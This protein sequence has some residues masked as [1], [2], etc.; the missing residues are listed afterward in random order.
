[1]TQQRESHDSHVRWL[2]DIDYRKEF[3]SEGAKLEIAAELVKAR[4][5]MKM[6]QSA[7]AK[8]ADTSQAYIAR[9]ERGDA[10]PTIGNIGRLFACMWLKPRIEPIPMEPL[11]SIESV[12]M[13]NLND[14]EIRVDFSKDYISS[15]PYSLQISG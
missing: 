15:T 1:M 3:G 4:E 5:M 13:Q 14:S 10:N 8:L 7:L 9:L 6:T 12:V 11:N 2:Q